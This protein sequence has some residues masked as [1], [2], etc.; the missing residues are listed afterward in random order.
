M[1][2]F[3]SQQAATLRAAIDRIIPPDDYPGGWDTGVGD[4]LARQF[5]R[6][7]APQLGAYQ[8]GLDQIDSTAH[9]G[10]GA[11]FAELTPAAQDALLAQ[12]EAGAHGDDLARFFRLLVGHA[13]EGFYGDPGNGG[14][15]D[16]VAWRMI[17]FEVRG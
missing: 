1:T 9:A 12:I 16:Q 7:L 3:S 10:S 8:S 4:Y 2:P 14:N 17:G 5:A 6:D 15:R 13:M 11:I